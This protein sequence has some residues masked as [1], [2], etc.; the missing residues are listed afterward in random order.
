MCRTEGGKNRPTRPYA[1]SAAWYS[2]KTDSD[3]PQAKNR[4]KIQ[5]KS[6][7][8]KALNVEYRENNAVL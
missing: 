6:P 5:M 8:T 1:I 4:N 7:P 3:F 2:P